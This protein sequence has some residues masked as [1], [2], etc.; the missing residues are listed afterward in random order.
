MEEVTERE[1][2]REAGIPKAMSGTVVTAIDGE[3]KQK[4]ERICYKGAAE[5][6]TCPDHVETRKGEIRIREAQRNTDGCKVRKD[7]GRDE[8]GKT[9]N[10][11]TVKL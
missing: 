3:K 7:K 11:R 4:E 6:R 1:G 5:Y 8:R 9:V 10:C 2:A